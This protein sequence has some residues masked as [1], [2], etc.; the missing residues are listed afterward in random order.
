SRHLSDLRLATPSLATPEYI[1]LLRSD[2]R[3]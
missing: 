3:R 2:L 1:P